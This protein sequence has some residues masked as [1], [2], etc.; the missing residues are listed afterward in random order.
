MEYDPENLYSAYVKAFI[1]YAKNRDLLQTKE[2]LLEALSKD[3][4]RWDII[5]EV[6]Q[7]CYFMRDYESAYTYYKRF[8]E[9]KEALNLDIS[10]DEDAKI[11]VVLSKIGRVEESEKY[12]ENFKEYAENDQSIYKHASLAAYYSYK[13][14]TKNAIEQMRLFSQEDNYFYWIII[15]IEMDPLIDNIKDLP[16]FKKIFND[17]ES[18]FWNNHKQ[19]KASLEE[20]KLL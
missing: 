11:G 19:I 18:K 12:F 8:T 3:S 16:E 5:K 14:D 20:K 17:I 2:L 7:I 1:L 10:R 15:F 9:I 13:G 6:A 4:T